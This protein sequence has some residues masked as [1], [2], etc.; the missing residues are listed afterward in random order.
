VI[1]QDSKAELRTVVTE[2]TVGDKWLVSKGLQPGD[3]L[4]V[5]GLG[6]IQPGQTVTPVAVA[7][8]AAAESTSTPQAAPPSAA[9]AGDARGPA[10]PG[11]ATRVGEPTSAAAAAG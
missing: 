7:T 8:P 1:S 4:I 11:Q 10:V 9:P 3:R 6:R 2:R 5:E